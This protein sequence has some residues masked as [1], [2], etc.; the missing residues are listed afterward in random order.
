MINNLIDIL[1]YENIYLIAN[2]G[3]IP[4]W[5]L[6]IIAPNHFVTSFFVRSIIIPLILASAYI[7]ISYN[8][9]IEENILD[10][11]ELYHGLSGL[12]SMFSSEAFLL[13]FW[14][15]FLAISLFVGT[16]ISR[17]ASRFMIPRFLTIISLILTYF[18]GPIG[19]VFYWF[20]R[21]FFSKKI[22]LHD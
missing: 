3:V 7:F 10:S 22:N 4:F 13:I 15:H 17:D 11:F 21:I 5:L 6:L 20:I 16:W 1:T 18:T 12:Y 19:L 14:L 8:I 2:W 9:Y